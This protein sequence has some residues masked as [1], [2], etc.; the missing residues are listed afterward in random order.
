MVE[1]RMF[2][3][4]EVHCCFLTVYI[5]QQNTYWKCLGYYPPTEKS[6]DDIPSNRKIQFKVFSKVIKKNKKL[7]L[8]ILQVLKKKKK[9]NM[10]EPIY[11]WLK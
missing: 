11:T 3:H 10:E 1:L 4:W 2:D 5:A 8:A 6:V 9:K 7:P